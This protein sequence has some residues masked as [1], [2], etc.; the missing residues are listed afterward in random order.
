VR[1]AGEDRPTSRIRGVAGLLPTSVD[2]LF[3]GL[4]RYSASIRLMIYVAVERRAGDAKRLANIGNA[5]LLISGQCTELPY[6]P[7]A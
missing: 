4:M 6:F 7:L 2:Q 1:I 3:V 5:V